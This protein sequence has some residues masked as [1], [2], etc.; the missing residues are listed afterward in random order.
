MWDTDSP[1]RK[2]G[3]WDDPRTR[4][5]IAA[6]IAH[7]MLV[8]P[9][10][11]LASAVSLTFE[12]LVTAGIADNMARVESGHL[13][14]AMEQYAPWLVRAYELSRQQQQE[15][16]F[17]HWSLWIVSPV[18]IAGT[19][20]LPFIALLSWRRNKYRESLLAAMVFVALLTNACICGVMAGPNDRYEARIAWLAPL[21]SA[22]A[23]V[24][25]ASARKGQAGIGR[26]RFRG[27]S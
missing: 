25:L 21:A 13:H 3:G 18:S 19:F 16:D 4:P 1:L 17:E 15:V 8:H 12:Q 7:S 5:K 20:A 22:L 10:E 11:H 27:K 2:I 23:G 9:L 14:W 6:I 24:G 26:V